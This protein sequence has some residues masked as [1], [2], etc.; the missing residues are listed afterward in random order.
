MR[1]ACR[2]QNRRERLLAPLS[3]WLGVLAFA[4]TWA[5]L[6]LVVAG[7]AAAVVTFVAVAVVCAAVVWVYGSTVVEAGPDGLRVGRAFLSAD[8][9]GAVTPLDRTATRAA[10][11]PQA[12][13]RAWLHVRP[14]VDTAVRVDVADPAD[15]TPYWLVSTRRPQEVA[16]ALGARPSGPT[17]ADGSP[18]AD[19]APDHTTPD[20]R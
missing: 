13:A 14:Y 19:T 10:L 4:L 7:T 12:D 16:A 18:S 9:L 2:V 6:L 20:P 8:A 1:Q 15:P 17:A 5:W 11:G 3:W